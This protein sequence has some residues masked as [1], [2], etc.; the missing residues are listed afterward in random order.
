VTAG[1]RG[2]LRADVKRR[3]GRAVRQALPQ[4]GI[5][6]VHVRFGIWD[7]C[8]GHEHSGCRPIVGRCAQGWATLAGSRHEGKPMPAA[9]ASRLPDRS[10]LYLGAPDV[11]R[12]VQ[13]KGLSACLA[14]V[15]RY[16]EED[17]GRWPAFEMSARVAS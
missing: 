14:G 8:M 17:F 5:A 11:V 2:V 12:I 1:H 3:N 15:A 7:G 10:T 9:V 6:P 13:R 4:G 16:I